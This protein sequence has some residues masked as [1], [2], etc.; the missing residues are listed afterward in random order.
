M[1]SKQLQ[2]V[3]LDLKEENRA[4]EIKEEVGKD[5]DSEEGELEAKKKANQLKDDIALVISI[6]IILVLTASIVFGKVKTLTSPPHVSARAESSL[7][8]TIL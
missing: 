6:I 2:A 7:W 3:D 5:K 1:Y 4:R 8:A